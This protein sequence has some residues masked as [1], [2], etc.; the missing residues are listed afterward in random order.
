ME[1]LAAVQTHKELLWLGMDGGQ[2]SNSDLEQL[3]V[4]EARPFLTRSADPDLARLSTSAS[5]S[6]MLPTAPTGA[7]AACAQLACASLLRTFG[8]MFAWEYYV[9]SPVGFEGN[10]PPLHMLSPGDLSKSEKILFNLSPVY[11]GTR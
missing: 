6:L 4:R 11:V 1:D 2:L 10:L 5:R 8:S 3:P 7:L 9:C